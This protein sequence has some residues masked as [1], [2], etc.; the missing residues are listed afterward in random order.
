MNSNAKKENENNNKPQSS[1]NTNNS[2]KEPQKPSVNVVSSR[3]FQGTVTSVKEVET[4]DGNKSLNGEIRIITNNMQDKNDK[5]Y[6]IPVLFFAQPK[7][8]L[9]ESDFVSFTIA[10]LADERPY[11]KDLTVLKFSG[12]RYEAHVERLS[13]DIFQCNIFIDTKN[14]DV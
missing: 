5:Q 6:K 10:Y 8:Q 13:T 12:E 3:R 1:S 4:N 9:Q 11:A 2:K 7:L 14:I